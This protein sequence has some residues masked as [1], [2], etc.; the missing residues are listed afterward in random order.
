MLE[1]VDFLYDGERYEEL[2]LWKMMNCL[3]IEQ[4]DVGVKNQ[5]ECAEWMEWW[6]NTMKNAIMDKKALVGL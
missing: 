1:T 2:R 3:R 6:L 5:H 4:Q